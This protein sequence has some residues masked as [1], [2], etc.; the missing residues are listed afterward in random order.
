MRFRSIICSQAVA[1]KLRSKHALEPDEVDE[2]LASDPYVLRGKDGLY[3]VLGRTN[4]GRYL[5]AA[6][7]SLGAGGGRLVTARDM[8]RSERRTFQRR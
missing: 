7:A 6:T 4:A 8:D 1:E 2:A 3:L 5:T